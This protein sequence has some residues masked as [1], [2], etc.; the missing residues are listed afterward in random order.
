MTFKFKAFISYSHNDKTW[1][2]WLQQKLETYEIPPKLNLDASF[3]WNADGLKTLHPV[4]RDETE[5]P[6]CSSLPKEIEKCLDHSYTLIVLCS[7]SSINSKWVKKEISYYQDNYSNRRIIPVVLPDL[8]EEIRILETGNSDLRYYS[9]ELLGD[10][11]ITNSLEMPLAAKFPNSSLPNGNDLVVEDELN[12]EV[13]KIIA[14]ILNVSLGELKER[15]RIYAKHK[16][17]LQ[18]LPRIQEQLEQAYMNFDLSRALALSCLSLQCNEILSDHSGAEADR[19]QIAILRS[20][21]PKICSILNV[22]GDGRIVNFEGNQSIVPIENGEKLTVANVLDG[23][24]ILEKMFPKHK[25]SRAVVDASGVYLLVLFDNILMFVYKLSNLSEPSEKH[26]VKGK[27][28]FATISCRGDIAYVNSDGELWLIHTGAM[29]RLLF[30]EEAK[31]STGIWWYAKFSNDGRYVAAASSKAG[32]YVAVWEVGDSTVLCGSFLYKKGDILHKPI[33]M[34][35]SPDSSLLVVRYFKESCFVY[36]L[37]DLK[38][39]GT[40]PLKYVKPNGIEFSEDNTQ[41]LVDEGFTVS[42]IDIGTGQRYTQSP[43]QEEAIDHFGYITGTSWFYTVVGKN[44]RVWNKGSI[45][46]QICFYLTLPNTA[47]AVFTNNTLLTAFTEDKT[48]ITWNLQ[49]LPIF[50]C[51]TSF[52]QEM[53]SS[54]FCGNG[55]YAFITNDSHQISLWELVE[56]DFQPLSQSIEG[57]IEVSTNST[58]IFCREE[59]MRFSYVN[60]QNNEKRE[61]GKLDIYFALDRIAVSSYGQSIAF[62]RGVGN[63]GGI[64][65]T[66]SGDVKNFSIPFSKGC[67]KLV[68]SADGCYIALGDVS[69]GVIVYYTDSGEPHLIIPSHSSEI[70]GLAFSYDNSLLAICDRG[71]MVSIWEVSGKVCI[72]EQKMA[73]KLCR[74]IF[75]QSGRYLATLDSEARQITLIDRNFVNN[76]T[77]LHISKMWGHNVTVR[78][79][80]FACNGEVL[81]AGFSNGLFTAWNTKSGKLVL[82]IFN[83]DGCPINEISYTFGRPL[84]FRTTRGLYFLD[85][86]Q[87]FESAEQISADAK[88]YGGQALDLDSF[89]L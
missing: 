26:E 12:N 35:F 23:K 75:E 38:M 60:F 71:K 87:I 89:M 36:K 82:P 57:C 68:F 51:L 65:C 70:S 56:N 42:I 3:P 13:L 85:F 32:S 49:T 69:G 79:I 45:N 48:F 64:I 86:Q 8:S 27:S 54:G 41:I 58:G 43:I 25:I 46:A 33:E 88:L 21:L 66:R 78:S 61:F 7:P 83:I 37:P 1:A 39:L 28:A 40:Q 34:H 11:T 84:L 9:L 15:D 2:E 63:T 55:K 17:A 4:F 16:K 50:R 80:C 73:S 6:A 44:I 81:L 77:N 47:V 62:A 14:G 59:D 29:M 76:I 18:T 74:V 67:S 53:R 19:F 30:T 10:I 20:V 5:L 22:A 24:I 31:E 52:T 72:Y